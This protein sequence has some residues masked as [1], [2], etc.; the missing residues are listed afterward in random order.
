MSIVQ[1][2]PLMGQP[3][4]NW[5][6]DKDNNMSRRGLLRGD[7]FKAIGNRG[8][9]AISEEPTFELRKPEGQAKRVELFIHRPPHAVPESE[10]IAGCTR[11][12]ACIDV[13]PPH[14][15]FRI[16]ESDGLL[17][18]TPIIDASG[19]PCIMCEDMPCVP[20]CE[21]G[22]LRMDAPVAMGLAVIDED[23]CIAFQGTV[24]TVCVDQCPVENCMT[25]V[26]GRPTIDSETCT[27]CGV[28][29]YVC[30]VE[31]SAINLLPT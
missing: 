5:M 21:A 13:C 19:Q 17:A 18:G 11:C 31:G 15:I 20:A 23:A 22:V 28:C 25:M 10:F 30:P 12:D 24:C 26:A 14:A 3:S 27:G 2:E 4:E 9:K 8:A 6:S 16:P 29:L 1:T 7:W